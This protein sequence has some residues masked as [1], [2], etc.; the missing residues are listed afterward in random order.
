MG[1]K[2]RKH[3]IG[4]DSDTTN[5][6]AQ[7]TPRARWPK[8]R[9]IRMNIELN[10]KKYI[11]GDGVTG[12]V[13]PLERYC[14]FDYCFNHFQEFRELGV[15]H[16]LAN[17]ENLQQ[18][19]LQLGFYLASWGM[20][21]GSSVL[22][23][24]SAKIYETVISAIASAEPAIW[25]IDVDSYSDQNIR[26]I[27]RFEETLQECLPS[28]KSVPSAT[29]V[30]KIML[31]VFGNVPA[32]D[33]YFKKGFGTFTFS[34]KSLSKIREF[35]LSNAQVIEKSRICT[36]DFLTGERTLRKYT[37]AKVIDMCFFIEGG[38]KSVDAEARL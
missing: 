38:G 12:G 36:I 5:N 4:V 26:K 21:R 25:E 22:L 20:L 9:M 15:T 37:R 24:K 14:S 31:G 2:E 33:S 11:D 32:F 16:E 34:R 19:C 35:Y 29:L 17:K 23:Q 3:N 13:K 18:S 27:L 6:A 10:L 8:E 1:E 28:T 7:V 30:T